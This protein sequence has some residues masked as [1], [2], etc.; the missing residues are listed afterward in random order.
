ML[1]VTLGGDW[2]VL[3]WSQTLIGL[4]LSEFFDVIEMWWLGQWA[5]AYALQTHDAVRVP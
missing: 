3:I 1:L 4:T 5:L 2:P